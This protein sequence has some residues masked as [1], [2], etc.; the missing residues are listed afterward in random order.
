MTDSTKL[1]S[2]YGTWGHY[3]PADLRAA[4][5]REAH[6]YPDEPTVNDAKYTRRPATLLAAFVAWADRLPT[7]DK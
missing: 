7:E 4:F 3:T 2:L 6:L 1:E 5:P